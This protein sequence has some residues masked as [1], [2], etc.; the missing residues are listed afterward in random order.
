MTARQRRRYL[1]LEGVR[2]VVLTPGDY[3]TGEQAAHAKAA[4]SD[5][6]APSISD[7]K[8]D[9]ALHQ[10]LNTDLMRLGHFLEHAPPYKAYG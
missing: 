6:A 8:D 10:N 7:L 2:S 1:H 4:G 9:P 5:P 3:R